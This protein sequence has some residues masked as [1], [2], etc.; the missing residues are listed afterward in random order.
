MEVNETFP[1]VKE[2]KFQNLKF[3][4]TGVAA[5]LSWWDFLHTCLY[6]FFAGGSDQGQSDLAAMK[7]FLSYRERSF[8]QTKLKTHSSK[9][10]K[11]FWILPQSF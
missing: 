7:L 5:K 4:L 11:S 2:N 10:I 6:T 3:L 9:I 8:L 1:I